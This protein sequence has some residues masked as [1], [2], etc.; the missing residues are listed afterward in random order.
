MPR[1]S[2]I[3]TVPAQSTNSGHVI[4]AASA[5]CKHSF[6]S[7]AEA[8]RTTA[9]D[10]PQRLSSTTNPENGTISYQCYPDGTLQWKLYNDGSGEQYYYDSYQRVST[11]CRYL[12]RGVMDSNQT[13]EYTYDPNTGA[14]NS[15]V[16]AYGGVGPN[17]YQM[18]NQYTYTPGG[19]IASKTLYLTSARNATGSVSVNYTYPIPPATGSSISATRSATW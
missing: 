3:G 12:P 7:G 15:V 10:R 14:L 6:V 17:G 19:K 5:P 8:N 16:F 18:Q 11:I 1:G 9:A 13:Q 4:L 2:W